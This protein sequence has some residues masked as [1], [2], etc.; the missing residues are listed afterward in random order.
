[1]KSRKLQC[2]C[3]GPSSW[4]PVQVIQTLTMLQNLCLALL[5]AT[6]VLGRPSGIAKRQSVTSVVNLGNDTGVP[7]HLASGR[8]IAGS[9]QD[10][11]TPK[12]SCQH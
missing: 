2:I 1:M 4:Q 5:C 11:R 10:L 8:R 3:V 12:Q 9:S 7:Q 6:S